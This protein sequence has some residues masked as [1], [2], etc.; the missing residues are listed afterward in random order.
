M[1]SPKK[2]KR[3]QEVKR[4]KNFF[5][6]LIVIFILW[7]FIAA[8]IY[9]VDPTNFGVIPVFFILFFFSS[10]LTFATLFA[11]TGRGALVSAGLTLFLILRYLGVGNVINLLLIFGVLL[12]LELYFSKI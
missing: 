8:L 4:R 12:S 1:A 2:E 11:N 6:T 7:G 9:L 3:K 5:P 10:F